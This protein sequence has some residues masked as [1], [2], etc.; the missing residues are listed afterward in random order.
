MEGRCQWS[1]FPSC[2]D[3]PASKV[4]NGGNACVLGDGV[5]IADLQTEALFVACRR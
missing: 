4:S 5:G 3:I 1:A 2:G